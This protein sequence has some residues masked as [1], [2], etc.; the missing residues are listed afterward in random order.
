MAF[1]SKGL[2]VA[3]K[4]VTGQTAAPTGTLKGAFMATT[5][6][7][8]KET[9]QFFADVSSSV[10]SGTTVRTIA[11]LDVRVDTANNRIEIDFADPTE[12]PVTASTN[13]F[14]LYMDTGTA[15]TSPLIVNGALS[16]TLSPVGGTLTL[17]VNAEGLAAINY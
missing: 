9:H 16:A 6:T 17:T 1:Y 4:A 7:Q 14:M 5:Y 11:G 8:D 12:T 10:A 13:Q 2:E 15:A 3:V